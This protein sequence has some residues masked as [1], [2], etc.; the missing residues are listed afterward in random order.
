MG[1]TY[2]LNVLYTQL[3]KLIFAMLQGGGMFL[4]EMYVPAGCEQVE[5]ILHERPTESGVHRGLFSRGMNDN[6]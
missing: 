2:Y 6:M 5:D 1:N 4:C 3:Q